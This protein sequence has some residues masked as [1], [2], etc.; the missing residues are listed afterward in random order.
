MIHFQLMYTFVHTFLASAFNASHL[1]DWRSGS[2]Q[3]FV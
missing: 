1:A 2:A 3:L